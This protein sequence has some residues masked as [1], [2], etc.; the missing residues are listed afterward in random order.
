MRRKSKFDY[1]Q[2]YKEIITECEWFARYTV[3]LLR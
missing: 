2:K 1:K 3:E